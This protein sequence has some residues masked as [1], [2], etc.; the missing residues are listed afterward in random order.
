MQYMGN[1]VYRFYIPIWVFGGWNNYYLDSYNA[2]NSSSDTYV[3]YSRKKGCGR[4]DAT[5]HRI[6]TI[7]AKRAGSNTKEDVKSE[8]EGFIYVHEGSIIIQSMHNGDKKAITAGDD[9]YWAGWNN[10]LKLKRKNDDDHKY[11]TYFEFDWYVPQELA[12]GDDFYWG[13][14]ANIYKYSSQAHYESF[15]WAHDDVQNV[16]S[17]ETPQLFTPYLYALDDDGVTGYG[18]A[19]VQ[20]VVTQDPVS[21]HTS[22][23]SKEV[24]VSEKSGLIFVPTADSVQRF[25]SATFQVDMTK[26]NNS[27]QT[28]VQR[29]TVKSNEIHIPAYHRLYDLRAQEL[30]DQQQSV[31]GD[32]GLTWSIRCPGAEDL[33]PGDMFEVERAFKEDFSDAVTVGMEYLNVDSAT[34][35]ME[36]DPLEAMR[37]L[38]DTTIANTKKVSES[39]VFFA[40]DSAGDPAIEYE[41]TLT[42]Q[43][44]YEP[45]RP[46]YYRV[47]RATS[48]VW[49]W[50]E[51]FALNTV[52]NKNNYL[53][54]L[55]DEPIS[56]TKDPNY[57]E[58][59]KIH[60]HFHLDN[61]LIHVE[62]DAESACELTY[63]VRN[64][65]SMMPIRLTFNAL[66]GILPA[67]YTYKMYYL[68]PE[69]S[70]VQE[71]LTLKDGNKLEASVQSGSKVQIS[72]IDNQGYSV[73]TI[74]LIGKLDNKAAYIADCELYYA[75]D[76]H[77][78]YSN[79][80]PNEAAMN[81]EMEAL[82]QRY[83][84]PDTVR[85]TLYT[86]LVDKVAQINHGEPRCNWDRN[87][88]LYLRRVLVE[89]NDTI[90][91]AVPADSIIRQ[92]DGSWIAHMTDVIDMPC[93]HYRYAVRLDQRA[94]ALK[95]LNPAS[96]N[97]VD[98]TGPDLYYNE[99]AHIDKFNA[100]QG[101]DRYGV[102]LSWE[103]TPGGVDR[104]DLERREAGS[105]AVFDPIHSTVENNYRDNGTEPGVQY[106]YRVSVTY[107][108]HDTTTTNSA[109]TTGFRSPYGLISG[110][111]HYSDGSACPGVTVKLTANG[112]GTNNEWT[113]ITDA[114][115]K[116]V[117][118]SLLYG[119][120]KE[121]SIIPTST[122]AQF[123]FNGQ[124]TTSVT[125]NAANPVAEGIEFDNISSV[126]V[127]GRILYEM[128]S[129]PVRDANLMLDGVMIQSAGGPIKTDAAGNFEIQVPDNH[130]FTLQAVKDGH[131]FVG[132]GYVVM[133]NSD[134]L[135]L[136]S[137]LDGVRIWDNTKVRL[138]GRIVG[139]RK[140]ALKPLGF[141]LS[142]NNLGDDLQLVLELE[143]D[144]ISHIV[145]D[146]NDLTHDTLNFTVDHIVHK[147][148]QA[149]T[150]GVTEVL[151]EKKRIII[152][153][154]PN[155]GEYCADLYPVKYKITQATARGYSTLF[156]DGKTSEVLDLSNAATKHGGEI[157]DEW[158]SYWNAKFS[159][160][161]RSPIDISCTQMRY[162]IEQDF[163]GEQSMPRKNIMNEIVD[164][165][166]VYTDSN[167]VKHYT[168]GYPVFMTGNYTFRVTAHEDYYY[169]N[170]KNGKHE[171]VRI[172]GGG[173]KVYNGLHDAG[174]ARRS[175]CSSPVGS[176]QRRTCSNCRR[177]SM[178]KDR[179][180]SRSRWTTYRSTTPVRMRC[181][182]WICPSKRTVSIS[183]NRHSR[184]M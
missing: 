175:R 104:Y 28:S 156:A 177:S 42:S 87:A 131:T 40:N 78:I 43:S 93:T 59:K 165:P 143:G 73:N 34:Y 65:N 121:Y 160:T 52:L 2:R 179:W 101:T 85:H 79:L 5:V 158:I 169:N 74:D 10:S 44:I 30:L 7:A 84:L 123:R 111:I 4:G 26:T 57:A 58:N 164:I 148:G 153:P 33:I 178:R 62:P 183:R 100:T 96:L 137:P 155:T 75:S 172:D 66:E 29:Y 171:E 140:Q 81:A 45:G 126:R 69:G 80:T 173:L 127:T 97:P 128:S 77:N 86:Q 132:E 107:T 168:F 142:T 150:T 119:A 53:A 8:G 25:Y 109:T 98:I 135:L 151:Y 60:F 110:R 95:V 120:G 32:V 63:S 134:R 99:V 159:I 72:I 115:G 105:N 12:N 3:W 15:W 90:E 103:Q 117:F 154:D 145:R 125:L 163:Y 162:G 76:H 157:E 9:T 55:A 106:E 118:D 161:Y 22:L 122:Y 138:A 71:M 182:Y 47:R 11:I 68:P 1:G 50:R 49:G 141:G 181:T 124:S 83:P 136:T 133:N 82:K 18:N 144:N 39:G 27:S 36:D 114:K 16:L 14:S 48:A 139:G 184:L 113:T 41:A 13:V 31:T 166:L 21:Y 6:A 130:P 147:N 92:A 88:I 70:L 46:V 91:L 176:T 67:N 35:T 20:Y 170:D 94:S 112:E 152:K 108:C 24:P 51:G 174:I 180:I 116:Y 56:Y 17:P 146:E 89:T 23:D 19:A 38:N 64:I 102:I 167:D 61:K 129:I 149:D 37:A 54:P